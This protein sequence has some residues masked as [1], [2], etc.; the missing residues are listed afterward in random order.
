MM[1]GC[2]ASTLLPRR[3]GGYIKIARSSTPKC[4][5][6]LQP[7]NGNG[8]KGGPKDQK[9]CGECGILSDSSFPTGGYI[10]DPQS[11][12]PAPGEPIPPAGTKICGCQG[13]GM[14]GALGQHCCCYDAAKDDI[15]C[16][17][18]PVTQPSQCCG[19]PAKDCKKGAHHGPGAPLEKPDWVV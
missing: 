4:D 18:K 12:I 2:H 9:V 15:S 3:D 7:G 17:S 8:C 6:D 13:D 1:N 11:P 5:E 16:T 14:C 19:D 10:V